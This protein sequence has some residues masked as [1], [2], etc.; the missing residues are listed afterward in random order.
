MVSSGRQSATRS[1]AICDVVCSFLTAS[2]PLFMSSAERISKPNISYT[3]R[4]HPVHP[5]LSCSTLPLSSASV[6]PD[7]SLIRNL[8]LYA[9]SISSICH[10]RIYNEMYIS[11]SAW[12]VVSTPVRLGPVRL[13]FRAPVRHSLAAL[14]RCLVAHEWCLVPDDV[15]GNCHS[16]CPSK[17]AYSLTGPIAAS[18][19]RSVVW[20][21]CFPV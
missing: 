2:F 8:T 3:M 17:C 14:R 20:R 12:P 7:H 19:T 5:K 1:Q 4:S 18:R 9:V 11:V 10:L 15:S 6:M 16:L 13:S 21:K